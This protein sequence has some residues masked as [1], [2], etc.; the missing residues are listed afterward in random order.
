MDR[1]LLA[2]GAVIIVLILAGQY[3]AYAHQSVCSIDT[4]VNGS[5]IS[6]EIRTDYDTCYTELHL[7]NVFD[8]PRKYYVLTDPSYGS[9]MSEDDMKSTCYLL[10]REIGLCASISIES[11]TSDKIAQMMDS[12]LSTGTFDIG[13]VIIAGAIPENIYD[14]TATKNFRFHWRFNSCYS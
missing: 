2:I 5:E 3:F 1:K 7:K 9:L 11:A 14:G 12:S 4:E 6:Y 8:A 13:L 10:S